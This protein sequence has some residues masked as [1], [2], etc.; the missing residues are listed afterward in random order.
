MRY[1]NSNFQMIRLT[2]RAT[3][4][5]VPPILIKIMQERL[6]IGVSTQPEVFEPPTRREISEAFGNV[7]VT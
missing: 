4:E 1:T 7:L 2:I 3:D 6:E 5:S